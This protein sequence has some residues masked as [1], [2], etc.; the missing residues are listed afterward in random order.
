MEQRVTFHKMLPKTQSLHGQNT[1][2]RSS[3]APPQ[4]SMAEPSRAHPPPMVVFSYSS[5]FI[6]G[7]FFCVWLKNL[8]ICWLVVGLRIWYFVW[9]FEKWRFLFWAWIFFFSKLIYLWVLGRLKKMGFDLGLSTVI[10]MYVNLSMCVQL[11]LKREREREICILIWFCGGWVS[12]KWEEWRRRRKEWERDICRCYK[13]IYDI[14]SVKE[15]S[16]MWTPVLRNLLVFG[17]GISW[18][19]VVKPS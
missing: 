15:N 16:A 19:N 7:L 8:Y 13:E 10:C 3:M 2:N 5:V 6:F 4:T 17:F 11:F 12:T 18:S 9:G 14:Q 1:G